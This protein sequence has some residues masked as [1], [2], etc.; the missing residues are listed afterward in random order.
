[1]NEIRNI[2]IGFQLDPEKSQICYYDRKSQ[3]PVSLSTKVGSSLYEFPT[4]LC[5]IAGKEEW[6][7]GVEA[8]YFGSQPGGILVENLYELWQGKDTRIVDRKIMEPWELM[9]VFFKETMRLL[10]VQDLVKCISSVMITC[11]QLS[12]VFV[13]NI[14]MAFSHMGFAKEVC[15]IQ[16]YDESF[17]YYT[18]YQKPEVWMRKVA[19]YDFH[20]N[21]VTYQEMNID[22]KTRPAKVNLTIPQDFP[23]SE[24]PE[25]WDMDFYGIIVLTMGEDIFSGIFLIGE[26]FHKDW[27]EKS[28]SLLTRSRKHVFYGNNLYVKGACYGAKEKAE[29]K[30]LKDFLYMGKDL[31][32]S[33]VGMEMI[34]QGLKVYYPLVAA[35]VNWY[36][37][38]QEC[39]FILDDAEEL[40]FLLSPMEGGERKGYGMALPDLPKRPNRTTRLHM[41]VQCEAPDRCV[42]RV[43][44]M[45]FGELFPSSGLQWQETME[46]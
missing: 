35:G 36:E 33:N 24:M 26:E 32:R 2:I 12:K 37:S 21:M 15:H 4:T 25:Q 34:S 22:R 10:G 17:F 40:V 41:E 7:F 3:E 44:D 38:Y 27:A 13:E 30:R 43:K 6:H 18:M 9:A 11:K 1:M 46:L 16:D 29:E 23:L 19:L 39:D 42:I 45:G 28:L 31:V 5:K 8:E 20:D 14:R